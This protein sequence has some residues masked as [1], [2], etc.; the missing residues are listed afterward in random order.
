MVAFGVKDAD[1]T[2]IV[3]VITA[4]ATLIAYIVGEGMVDVARAGKETEKDGKNDR[5]EGD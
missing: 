1:I 3:G 5:S 4:G 2:Q